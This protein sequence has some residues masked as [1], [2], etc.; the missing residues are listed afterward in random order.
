[1]Q[2]WQAAQAFADAG[3]D[4]GVK[5]CRALISG[6]IGVPA[7]GLHHSPQASHNYQHHITS[8]QFML[9]YLTNEEWLND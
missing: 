4:L 6:C 1:M 7:L 8:V 3:S 2:M 5:H 9:M